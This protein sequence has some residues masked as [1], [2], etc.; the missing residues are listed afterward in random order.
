[1]LL[2]YEERVSAFFVEPFFTRG[3][4]KLFG[5]EEPHLPCLTAEE[6]HLVFAFRQQ[7]GADTYRLCYC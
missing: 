6:L 2:R 7:N 4:L 5:L 3:T 1:M